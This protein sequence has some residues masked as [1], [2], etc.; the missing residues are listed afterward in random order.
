MDKFTFASSVVVLVA[1]AEAVLTSNLHT[2][3][4]TEAALR[5]D[6]VSR[7]LFPAVFVVI[8]VWA[9]VL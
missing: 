9:F 4:R 6:K 3:G 7:W 5:V 8:V 2:T 1:L